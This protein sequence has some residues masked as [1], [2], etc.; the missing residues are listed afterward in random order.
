MQ[1]ERKK[2]INNIKARNE[3]KERTLRQELILF[4]FVPKEFRVL[5]QRLMSFHE[6]LTDVIIEYGNPMQTRLL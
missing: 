2:V 4:H 6:K 3:M 1:D 5:S